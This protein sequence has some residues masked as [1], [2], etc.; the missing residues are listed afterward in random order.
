MDFQVIKPPSYLSDIVR[1]FW[2]FECDE[3]SFKPRVFQSMA[4]GYAEMIFQYGGGFAELNKTPFYLR[5]PKS[6]VGQFT[7]TSNTGMFGVRFFPNAMRDLLGIPAGE[8]VNG[9]YKVSELFGREAKELEDRLYTANL[10]EKVSLIATFLGRLI[11]YSEEDVMTPV[12]RNVIQHEGDISIRTLQ[13]S[14]GYSERQF[15]RRFAACSGFSPKQFA[16]IIRFQNVKQKYATGNFRNLAELAQASNYFDQSHFIRE[17]KE[18]SGL[19][20]KTYFGIFVEPPETP[21]NAF[22]WLL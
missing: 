9:V 4:D 1:C 21:G 14:S 2:M 12:V 15:E 5:T 18:F 17:F 6:N 16:R 22:N 7:L 11:K 8:L 20:P 3:N 13:Q 10:A 19:H